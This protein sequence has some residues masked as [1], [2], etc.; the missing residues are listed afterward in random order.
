[1]FCVVV[2]GASASI[3]QSKPK[4]ALVILNAKLS[5]QLRVRSAAGLGFGR[6]ERG[7]VG[8]LR[9]ELGHRLSFGFGRRRVLVQAR[10]GERRS[11]K[12]VFTD[13]SQSRAGLSDSNEEL[14]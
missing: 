1:M 8:E 13:G 9:G 3:A 10:S 4:G 11:V 2:W 7:S 5:R 12:L 6:R 14:R